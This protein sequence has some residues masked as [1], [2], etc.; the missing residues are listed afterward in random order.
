MNKMKVF[1]ALLL[2]L[3][4]GAV[5]AGAQTFSE[6]FNYPA[7]SLLSSN[8]WRAHSGAGTNSIRVYAPGL[9]Y[10]GYV[11]SGIGNAAKVDTAGEDVSRSFADSITSGSVYV[12]LLMNVLKGSTGDYCVHLGPPTISSA[13]SGKIFVRKA[14]NGYITFG[15]TKAANLGTSVAW[16]DS[17]YALNTTYFLVLKYKFVSGSANDSV[18]LFINP[19]LNAIEPSPTLKCLDVSGTDAVSIGGIALRQGTAALAP[20]LIVDGIRAATSWP[21]IDGD[22]PAPSISDFSP[23]TGVAG[24]QVTIN[25]SN[26]SGATAVTFN[27]VAATIS[28]NSATSI[29]A[30]VPAGAASGLIV[31]TTAGGSATSA[32][33][34][35]VITAPAISQ[36]SPASGTAGTVVT[37]RGNY[38]SGATNV[39]FGGVAG[40]LG[41]V[42]DTLLTATVPTGA[43]SGPISITTPGGTSSSSTSFIIVGAPMIS[44]FAP[45]SGPVGATVV[46][47]GSA[48]A[49]ATSVTLNGTAATIAANTDTSITVTIPE[50]ATSGTIAVTTAGGTAV[51]S[52]AFTV[53]P[54]PTI[55]A[56]SPLLGTPGTTVT[57]TGTAL[58]N[59]TVV[60]FNG[61]A[62]VVSSD[63][64]TRI[65][66]IVPANASSG[67]IAVTTV[68]GTTVSSTSF[69]VL[70]TTVSSVANGNWADS[71]TW[72]QGL[73]PQVLQDV[74][75]HHTLTLTASDTAKTVSLD[76]A[77]VLDLVGYKLGLAGTFTMLSG[78]E[79]RM[80]AYNPIPGGGS[81]P[82]DIRPGSSYL[83]Y[84]T[85]TGFYFSSAVSSIAFGNVTWSSTA[86][87]TPPAGVIIQ[88]NLTKSGTGELRG[89]NNVPARTTI[90]KGNVVIN[91]GTL[92]MH[93]GD[94]TS[95]NGFDVDGDVTVNAGGI[96]RGVNYRGTGFLRVGGNVINNGG[97]IQGAQPGKVTAIGNFILTFKGTT[98]AQFTPG[99]TDTLRSVIV[100]AGKT[101]TLSGNSLNI[102]KGYALLDSGVVDLGTNAIKDSGSVVVAAGSKVRTASTYG[103][104][105]TGMNGCFQNYGT[106]TLDSTASYD[107]TGTAAQITG[108]GL[109]ASVADLTIQNAAGVA[110]SAP[111]RVRGTLSLNQGILRTGSNLLTVS[112]GGSV[113]RSTGW[114]FGT[115]GKGVPAGTAAAAFEIGDS[116]AYAPVSVT[117]G[118]VAAAGL[119]TASTTRGAHPALASS[120]LQSSKKVNRYYTVTNS[121]VVFDSYA[122]TLSWNSSDVDSAATPALFGVRKYDGGSWSSPLVAN[123]LATSIQATGNTSFSDFVAGETAVTATSMTFVKGWNL[124]S[125]PQKATDSTTTAVFPHAVSGSVY[126]YLTGTYASAATVHPGE[127]YWAFYAQN[128]SGTIQ[129]T[130]TTQT[131]VVVTAGSRWVLVGG[132][133]TSV[134]TSLLS[135]TPSGS[136]L[137]SSLYG[138]NGSSYSAATTFEPGKGYWVYVTAP[139]TVTIA[140][141]TS[142]TVKSAAA[143]TL[144]ASQAK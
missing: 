76:S 128:D 11:G 25:G 91:A 113:V 85:T 23:T 2:L 66:A 112:A 69:R 108:D 122:I 18:F 29:V 32:S 13:F 107:F 132:P 131:S 119:L 57:I 72:D 27:G 90:V 19:A 24:T 104:Q 124:V 130:Q 80:S 111:V 5:M 41:S 38:F 105:A 55:T 141:G 42:S 34:F 133:T 65:V 47:L 70:A 98:A 100:P 21:T 75:I 82:Y 1:L 4:A 14:N 86:N 49:G 99:A 53:I 127:G 39:S 84:G 71:T 40:T 123:A 30:I 67:V 93:N 136:I 33:I 15:L 129:G 118:N 116:L 10:D 125:I 121:G 135:T 58:G 103:F 120:G 78:S 88:G 59:A 89:G 126:G 9:T 97:S 94:T 56:V 36:F 139:C 20:R 142:G 46:I 96:L 62:A 3:L 81:T 54:A 73:K 6:D 74:V 114:V 109:P 77:G 51:S 35:T 83:F 64:S 102:R 115:L 61:V 7:D 37:I 137:N 26:L 68:A 95:V 110:L 12:G 60:S 48:L 28:S 92:T 52:S 63:S 22:V 17:V 87:A 140:A 44:S 45:A 144:T 8:G 79:A 138:W 50:G 16:S 43:I 31:V 143:G 134:S 101:V 106:R 117:F